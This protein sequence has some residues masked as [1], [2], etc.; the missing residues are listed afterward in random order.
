MDYSIQVV[1]TRL[2]KFTS[3]FAYA[4]SAGVGLWGN[5]EQLRKR[6][7]HLWASPALVMIWLSGYFLTLQAR[8]SLSELWIVGGFVASLAAQV[9]LTRAARE[10]GSGP[11]LRRATVGLLLL[12]LGL[13]VVRPTWESLLP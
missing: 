13:M 4:A 12:A 9:T 10:Q 6:A 5:A 7:V 8:V 2:V 1:L 3:V 11:L